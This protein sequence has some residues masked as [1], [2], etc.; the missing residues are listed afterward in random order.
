MFKLEV[1]SGLSL[2]VVSGLFRPAKYTWTSVFHTGYKPVFW[3]STFALTV[4][5]YNSTAWLL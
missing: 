3:F 4:F 5:S 2:C 1:N